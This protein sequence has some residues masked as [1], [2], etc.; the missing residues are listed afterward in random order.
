MCCVTG[1]Q[2]LCGVLE[3]FMRS[4]RSGNWRVVSVFAFL[5]EVLIISA[6]LS[7]G[8]FLDVALPSA[9]LFL[10]VTPLSADLS[11]TVTPSLLTCFCL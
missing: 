1:N 4:M 11:L 7:F 10:N 8:L 6:A 2:K 3:S 5:S 9:D